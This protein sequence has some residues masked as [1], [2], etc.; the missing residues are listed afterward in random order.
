M[1]EGDATFHNIDLNVDA[2]NEEFSSVFI[3][4]SGY[5][6]DLTI[7][8]PWT[9]LMSEPVAIFVNTIGKCNI[10]ETSDFHFNMFAIRILRIFPNI[11]LECVM[12]LKSK[13]EKL[14]ISKKQR[15]STSNLTLANNTEE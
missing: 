10:I 9:K 1:W 5:I 6:R 14:F 3:F 11:C 2:L 7:H 13:E 4:T 8:V 12:K 15:N